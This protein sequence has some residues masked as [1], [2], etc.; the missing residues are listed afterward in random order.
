MKTCKIKTGSSLSIRLNVKKII[1]AISVKLKKYEG[2]AQQQ[3]M[4][5]ILK[6]ITYCLIKKILVKLFINC[7][8]KKTLDLLKQIIII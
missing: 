8:N 5:K 7:I 1:F 3:I 4:T 6:I 2:V